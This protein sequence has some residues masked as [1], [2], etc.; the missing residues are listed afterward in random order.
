MANLRIISLIVKNNTEI[1]VKFT[2]EL[3]PLISIDNISITA[4][5]LGIDDP[6]VLKVK[7]VSDTLTIFIQPLVSQA[8]YFITLNNAGSVFFNS[9][10]G[11]ATLPNDN[12]SNKYYF[13][14]LTDEDNPI[15]NSLFEFFR[16]NVYDLENPSLVYKYLDALSLSLSQTL[17]EIGQTKNDNYLTFTVQDELKTRG[18][19]AYDRLNEEGAYEI[20][21]V[22]LNPTNENFSENINIET[23]P[24]YPVSLLSTNYV[25]SITTSNSN[26]TGKFNL[27]SLIINCT[28]YPVIKMNSIRF[29]YNSILSPYE[30]NISSLGYQLLD[31]KYD[32]EHSFTYLLLDSNQVKLSDQVINDPLFSLENISSIEI[33]YD[34][35]NLGKVIEPN[36]VSLVSVISA[37]RE[38][39]PAIQNIVNLLKA[40]VV[41]A[42]N[43]DGEIGDITFID[44]NIYPEMDNQH[45]AFTNEIKFRFDYMPS[46]IGEY[47]IDYSTGNVYVFGDDQNKT[48]TGAYPPIAVYNYRYTFQQDIDYVFDD[49]NYDLVALPNGNL[50]NSSAIISYNFEQVLVK[51]IDYKAEV[52]KEEL[53]ERVDNRLLALNCI[54]PLHF[55]I[56]NVFR[57]FNETSG[58]IYRISRWNNE[59]IFFTYN[60]PPKILDIVN[61]RAS[62]DPITNETLFV[63][64]IISLSL[65]KN[66][67]KIFLQNNNIISAS[68]DSIGFKANS[69]V[70]FSD[71][72]IFTNEY[73]FDQSLSV[74]QNLLTIINVGDY[75]IDYEN[76]I[77]WVVVSTDQDLSIGTVI[78]KRGYIRPQNDHLISSNDIYYKLNY[79]SD[80]I[81]TFE[82]S[83]FDD[84][85]ILPSNIDV[86][87]ENY[88]NGNTSF[89]YQIYNGDIGTFDDVDF[90]AEV[91]DYV[92]YVR[93][94]FER[95]DL[96][97]SNNPIN[98]S[99]AST[100]NGKTISV[101][102]LEFQEYRNI[103]QDGSDYYV[104]VNNNVPYLSTNITV[105]VSVKRLSDDA[106]L[107]NG[108]G[109][110]EAGNPLK[111]ILPGI[112]SPQDN[113]AVLINYSFT[114]ADLSR[115]VVDYSKGDYMIDYSYLNDEIIIS[116]EY[117]DNVLDFSTSHRIEPGDNYYVSYKTGALR[118][119]LL[120]NFGTLI[121]I[122]ILNNLNVDFDRE[123][124]RDALIAAMQSFTQ[125]PTIASL[126]NIVRQI[127][128]SEPEIIESAFQNWTL[129][130]SLL[131]QRDIKT[132]GSPQLLPAKYGNGVL[133]SNSDQTIK[134]PIISNLKIEEGTMGMWV[135]PQ[136][137]GIDNQAEITFEIT[138][139]GYDGNEVLDRQV[140][141]GANEEHPDIIDG[142]FSII[143]NNNFLIG[144]PNKHKDG[145]YIYLKQDASGLF[146]RWYVDVLDGYADGYVAN[147][148]KIKVSTNGRFYDAKKSPNSVSS[149]GKIISGPGSITY[150]IK[151]STAI[152]EGFT[153]TADYEHYLFDFG[154][155][156]NENRFSIFRDASGYLNFKIIDKNK[157]S[158]VVS[159]D[160]SSWLAG[161]QHYVAVSWILNSKSQ[162]DEMHLFIDGE[163]VSNI[164]KYGGHISPRLHQKFRTIGTEE[165]I[166]EVPK[167]IVGSTDL[168][169][170]INDNEVSS[171]LNFTDLGIDIGDTI[172]IEE[173]GFN[174]SGYTITN[175]NGNTLTLSVNM[176]ITATNCNFTINKI[177]LIVN[178]Q[179]NIYNNIAISKIHSDISGADLTTTASNDS[180]S[181]A[182]I[183]FE[184]EGVQAGWL[185][186][187]EETG[188]EEYY[189]ITEVIGNTLIL[190]DEMPLSTSNSDFRIYSNSE[191]EIPGQRALFPAYEITRDNDFNNILTVKDEVEEND[192]L[193]IRTLGLNHAR[194][195][196]KYYVWGSSSNILNTRL[197]TPLLL[198]DINIYHT[199][200]DTTVIGPDNSTLS[201]GIF[202]SDNLTTD[203]PS[204]SDNGRT[205]A[206]TIAGENI[207]YSTSVSV[208]INGTI[209][210]TPSST[211]IVTFSENG[212]KNTIGQVSEI[213]YVVV[214]CKPINSSKNCLTVKLKEAYPITVAEN[215][216]VV[217]AIKYS[218][219]ML[220]GNTLSGNS[221]SAVVEDLNINFSTKNIGNYLVIYSPPSV[222]GQYLITDVSD[223]FNNITLSSNISSNFTGG[224]YEILNISDEWSGLQNGKFTFE[225][226]DGYQP[227]QLSQGIY[228]LDYHT[229]LS[230]PIENRNLDG[231]IGSDF[232]GNNQAKTIID[233]FL[234]LD[235]KL[236]D[237]RIG[238]TLGA[239][240]DGI[241]K[242]FNSI[243]P[244]KNN[245]NTLLLLH[246]DDKLENDTDVYLT[247]SKEFI[248]SAQSV[249]DNFNKS[250]YFDN[251]GLLVDNTGILNTKK[252]GTIE[253]WINPLSDTGND[254]NYRFYFDATGITTEEIISLNNAT[255]KIAGKTNSVIYIKLKNGD[256]LVD[257]FSGGSIDDDM[258]TIHLNKKLPNQN[259]NV[260]V[261]YVPYGLSGDRM[262][263]YKDPSGYV[264]FTIQGNEDTYQVRSPIFW[265]RNTWHKIRAQYKINQGLGADEVRLFVDGYEQG[266]VL[267][268]NG[269]LFGEHLVFGSSYV[270][271]SVIQSSIPFTDTINEFTIG[272]D[273][274]DTLGANALIDNFKISNVARPIFAPFGESTDPNYSTNLEIVY[275]TVEDLYTTFLMDFN[276]LSIKTT[277]FAFL[278]N[279]RTGLFDIFVNV[280]D[281][282]GILEENEKSKNIME[283]LLNTL[284]PANSRIFIRY[285]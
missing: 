167:N 269:L 129:G 19:G 211:E 176:P 98:F 123:R 268:G 130:N 153:F 157:N 11:D 220:V 260:I 272:S 80:K 277:D 264:N 251:K 234:I 93:G 124:Y 173:I 43:N 141:I 91:S 30:Y 41:D 276:K 64:E 90:V 285:N 258:Q 201:L 263:I 229:Y 9:L 111:F 261:S 188:F 172:Y 145:I 255:V 97:N 138:K 107:W 169:T 27:K 190:S 109:V 116:Y 278:K 31:S 140:F 245:Q 54:Q 156:V 95:I 120:R 66:I 238:E 231:F 208:E 180:V 155:D 248:Q 94:I 144:E 142:Q 223:D 37:S 209:N 170:T 105:N 47:S 12:I 1:D 241:T 76:G 100:F 92:K 162:K 221:G 3:N 146:N 62:F 113:D 28:K 240:Q 232:N 182:S 215:S 228:E 2:S 133:V 135:V 89:P 16:T 110:I 160:I 73:Y 51:N 49:E 29:I 235:T 46:R 246:F 44:P 96:L 22:G 99:T 82:F 281:S 222:A 270:G 57:V 274:S 179:I 65:T 81:K 42:N 52:H 253:F 75:Q 148:L 213:D 279:R 132:T 181:S 247:S 25:E 273:Y 230:I 254:P 61:E 34:Y 192:I 39:L 198:D 115:V 266:N 40:P 203:Q 35:K 282:F 87:A 168:S 257:Y 136:W 38:V 101:A 118:S 186:K 236:S 88:L 187:I 147:T 280:N 271:Q 184:D 175:V 17:Y 139:D 108:S 13:V 163:E 21:R 26:L 71:G 224:N 210:G 143:N 15:K 252:E 189:L 126:K 218:Y 256:Q 117:G 233:E 23:F 244:I 83:S 50:I 159:S 4:D 191:T 165:I 18:K 243:K 283:T 14:G 6:E 8:S 36:S 249:N 166:G 48:G 150:T 106:E 33:D 10:H 127:T 214:E 227:Y 58:E 185:L 84:Q 275:P 119:G 212:T 7:I 194:V 104:E 79:L 125:G 154:T 5:T 131:T 250:V 193:L 183:D 200:L 171:S 149:D 161:E 134:F 137:N 158:Y 204:L 60:Q 177:S 77:I 122:P 112:N 196:N 20:I 85:L 226:V 67:Y 219:Q 32:P 174:E 78:Y 102:P 216:S 74:S 267:F 202:T 206:I 259:I 59:K 103:I 237:T 217:P 128:H 152:A 207:D 68:E 63:S 55:P 121:D 164:L 284:K 242:R 56:T 86:A 45:P 53:S 262:S 205:I 265:K 69:S 239:N 24:N 178:T 199:L 114:I 151:N 225:M 197:P 72:N 70:S 195:R